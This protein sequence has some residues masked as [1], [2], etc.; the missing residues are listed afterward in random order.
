MDDLL[1]NEKYIYKYVPFN[2]N[3]LK[4][5]IKG[6]LWFCAPQN[7]NDPFD[8]EFTIDNFQ[9]NIEVRNKYFK[10]KSKFFIPVNRF[11]GSIQNE[12]YL[13]QLLKSDIIKEV[14]EK[15]GICCFSKKAAN[16]L[17]W[18]HYAD[19]HS[20]IC[21]IFNK[22]ELLES[23][24]YATIHQ[25]N[26]QMIEFKDENY[27]ESINK[28]KVF[29]DN[30]NTSKISYA[31]LLNHKKKE[32]RYEE[33]VRFVK[34]QVSDER[35]RLIQF[36]KGSLK[37]IIFGYKMTADNVYTL[38]QLVRQMK[39]YSHL[40]PYYCDFDGLNG[41][42]VLLPGVPSYI[43]LNRKHDF[44]DEDEELTDEVPKWRPASDYEFL[45]RNKL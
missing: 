14:K 11:D 30:E 23:F 17:M 38:D 31:Q 44:Y 21:L 40:M 34:Y 26:I 5:L 41:N 37:G 12:R 33:E 36:D 42:M 16:I 10:N 18:S 7:F 25:P 29:F 27:I 2:E 28:L 24:K 8:G 15:C 19:G 9:D 3:T 4:L 20:G 39:R 1:N 35:D 43:V 22:E 45:F 32:W 13:I 6:E